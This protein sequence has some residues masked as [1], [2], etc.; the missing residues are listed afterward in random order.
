[1]VNTGRRAY[2]DQTP[3]PLDDCQLLSMYRQM[4]LSRALDE[5]VWMLNR[6]GKAAIVAS[7]QGHEAAQIGS[8]W[9][10]ERGKDLFYIY[11]RDL[12]VLLTLGMTPFE[13]MC[14]FLAKQGEP[15]SGARQFPTHG[16]YPQYGIV[17]LSNVVATQIP[18]AVG[19][20]LAK[21]M[22]DEYGVVIT[23]FG[24]GASSVGECHEGMNFAAVHNL[25]IIFFCENNR[26]AISV[27][28]SRQMAVDSIAVRAEGY[29]MPG[30]T[31]DGRDI[32]AV[33]E[34]TREAVLRAR[35]GQGPTLIEAMVERYLPHTSDD[36][37]T[38][39]R[40]SKDIAE[41]R[42]GDPLVILSNDLRSKGLLEDSLDGE[43]RAE[44]AQ[45]V[46]DATDAVEAAPFPSSQDFYDHVY[47]L[48]SEDNK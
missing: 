31:V 3:P 39:Y 25:P 17:N 35:Q 37:D 4:V 29:G 28:L 19:A 18:Q 27:P 44:A 33:Y 40:S 34:A 6:Q 23:Y 22:K 20:A 46:N 32:K 38:R 30:V 14:G 36:D 43:I 24:D 9:A 12:A 8:A 13:I 11:Y 47:A 48:V 45:T 15:L 1:M 41:A 2:P 5:R 16:A 42:K 10:L 21:K 26:Y 7:A